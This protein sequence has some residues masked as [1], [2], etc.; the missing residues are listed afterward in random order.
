MLFFPMCEIRPQEVDRVMQALPPEARLALNTMAELQ[1]RPAE[2]V[3]RD[4]IRHYIEGK[5]PA[6]DIDAAME[7]I[8]STAYEA[9]YLIGRLRS[10]A[11]RMSEDDED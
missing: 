3:L 1:N 10:F 11:R 2:D 5:V 7:G 9:G 8:K 4:E 6:I